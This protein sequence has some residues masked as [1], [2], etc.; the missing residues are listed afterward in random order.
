MTRTPDRHPRRRLSPWLG[1]P[2]VIAA[3]WTLSAQATGGVPADVEERLRALESMVRRA[4][5]T[6]QITAPFDVVGPDGKPLLRVSVQHDRSVPVSIAKVPENNGGSVWLSAGGVLE[7]A[8]AALPLAGQVAV[9]DQ[10]GKLRAGMLGLG[11]VVVTDLKG[12]DLVGFTRGDDDGGRFA[13]WRSG[14]RVVDIKPDAANNAGQIVVSNGAGQPLAKL[15][16]DADNGG[17]GRVAVMSAAGKTTAALSG[18]MRGAGAVI[19]ANSSSQP[20][21]EMSVSDDGRGLVQVFG[22]G[23][24]P[25]AVLTQATENPGGLLQISNTGGPVANLTIGPSGGGFLQLSS[26]SG[27]PNVEA[28]SLPSG[29]GIVRAGPYYKCSPIQPATPIIAYGIPDCLLGGE[30]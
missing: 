13:I 30:K 28:G 11:K 3:T 2:L 1:A 5:T 27:V 21:A 7:V 26:P 17:A 4:G 24:R 20:L 14:Q 9:N 10:N 16:A 8:V 19:V 25:V 29:K 23:N 18:G 12:E 22:R 15:G 6:T